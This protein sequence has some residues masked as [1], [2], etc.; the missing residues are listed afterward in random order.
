MK[1][2]ANYVK[3]LAKFRKNSN[4]DFS[5]PDKRTRSLILNAALR[6]YRL[7]CEGIRDVRIGD[8]SIYAWDAGGGEW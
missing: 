5:Q 8:I 4:Y 6:Q 7:L 2:K 1:K 3:F